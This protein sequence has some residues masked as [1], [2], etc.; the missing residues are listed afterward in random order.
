MRALRLLGALMMLA[1]LTGC[2]GEDPVMPDVTGDKLDAAQTAIQD[3]GFDE[4]VEV[5]G[6]GLFGVLDESNWVV[7]DQSPKAGDAMTGA[8]RLVV[9]RSCGDEAEPTEEP[10]P[11]EEPTATDEPE[12]S[13]E[14]TPTEE[15]SEAEEPQV[16][17][18]QN[19]DE[20][21]DL[22]VGDYCA[23]AVKTFA[24]ENAGQTIEFDG[25]IVAM[26]NHG[27]YDT[28]YDIL[29]S[30]GDFDP[31]RAQGPA[32]KYEDVGILDLDLTGKVPN[33]IGVGDEFRFTATVDRYVPNTC[34]F[35]LKP[36]T[37]RV[38]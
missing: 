8:P 32:F 38:R 27:S 14:P 30:P 13:E 33:R 1:A 16:I 20:F 11:S 2:S 10:E 36:E 26:A 25:A 18:A 22:L 12:P 28:R 24:K 3:A 6:G 7:C 5:E 29:M 4:D 31:N 37:T 23:G 35:F 19:S 17:T 21:A 9:D 34:L 15:P